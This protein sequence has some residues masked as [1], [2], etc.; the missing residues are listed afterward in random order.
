MLFPLNCVR[1]VDI[2][3]ENKGTCHAIIS[4]TQIAHEGGHYIESI[5]MNF[6]KKGK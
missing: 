6:S 5:H 2:C 3:S 1:L 4:I